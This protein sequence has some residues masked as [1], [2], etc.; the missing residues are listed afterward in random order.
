MVAF[1]SVVLCVGL[2]GVG[3][4]A[5]SRLAG[6]PGAIHACADDGTGA[7]RIV[8]NAANCRRPSRHGRRRT[9]GERAVTW[10]LPGATGAAGAPGQ[11]GA[12]GLDGL[13]TVTVRDTIG[14]IPLTCTAT[15]GLQPL[16]YCSGTATILAPCES[17]EVATGGGYTA[18]PP[19]T[20]PPFDSIS[21][22]E[23]RPDPLGGAPTGWAITAT[24][25]EDAFSSPVLSAQL[26]IYATC[27]SSGAVATAAATRRSTV[28]ASTPGVAQGSGVFNACVNRDTGAVRLIGDP[29]RCRKPSRNRAHRTPGEYAVWWSAHGPTG[30]TGPTGTARNGTNGAS[31]VTIRQLT[32]TIPLACNETNPDSPNQF[33]CLGSGTVASSCLPGEVAA[34]GGYGTPTTSG[35]GVQSGTVTVEES[36]PDPTI[37]TPTDWTVTVNGSAFEIAPPGT[38]GPATAQITVYVI[39][40][41]P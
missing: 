24:A 14:T 40:V 17:G 23:S 3:Y 10:G 5:G 38:P 6:G 15:K 21:V 11:A 27:A 12:S 8:R 31:T 26:P 34:G 29:A 22:S 30:A 19:G 7:V 18:P 2:G 32:G 41:A 39:C 35:P 25:N 1:V 4:A 37:G 33:G 13:S 20:I 9:A 16:Y 36:R 28:P